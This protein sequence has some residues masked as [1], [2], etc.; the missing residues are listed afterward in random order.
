M[1]K[2]NDYVVYGLTGVCQI[3]DISKCEHGSSDETEYYVLNPVYV[4]NMTIKIPVDNPNISMRE[5]ITKDGV[6]SLMAAIPEE[7]TI[8]IDDDKL[9]CTSFKAA[10]RT[11]K[12]EE[13][14]KIIKMLYLEKQAKSI[15][16]KKLRKTDEDIMNSAEKQLSEEFAIALNIS[17]DEV[18]PYILEHVS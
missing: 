15:V 12:N 11:G 6:L 9:R 10:L 16:G 13:W 17:T 5:L 2:V 1:F 4:N 3:T 18:L 14:I 7:E 8:W